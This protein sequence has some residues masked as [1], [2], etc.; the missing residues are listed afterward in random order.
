MNKRN[1]NS[2]RSWSFSSAIDVPIFFLFLFSF[3][4]RSVYKMYML[5]YKCCNLNLQVVAVR[6]IAVAID[7]DAKLQVIISGHIPGLID[8]H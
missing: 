1:P 4:S 2:K 7:T 5:V 8:H 6:D 3:F